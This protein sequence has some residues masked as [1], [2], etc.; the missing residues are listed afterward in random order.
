MIKPII[1][2]VLL[3][4]CATKQPEIIMTTCPAVPECVRPSITIETNAD[5]VHAYQETDSALVQCKIARDT[6]ASCV[7]GQT[8]E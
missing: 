7:K 4:A 1:F 8:N 6:L 3:A 5:L 2:T